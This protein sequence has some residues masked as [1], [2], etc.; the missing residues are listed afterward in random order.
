VLVKGLV[1]FRSENSNFRKESPRDANEIVMFVVITN[2]EGEGI[3]YAVVG[4]GLLKGHDCP[5]FRDPSRTERVKQKTDGEEGREK[6]EDERLVADDGQDQ[7]SENA[8][9]DEVEES[10]PFEGLRRAK[11]TD[12]LEHGEQREP[13]GLAEHGVAENAVL[14]GRRNVGV[15]ICFVE[16]SVVLSVE[17]TEGDTRGDDVG[18]VTEEEE[19]GVE[20]GVAEDQVVS[21]FVNEYPLRV[22]NESANTVCKS[23][24]SEP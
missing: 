1:V 17:V 22:T 4:V 23:K 20:E 10:R 8:I 19:K 7:V 12:S 13:G 16:K 21:Q 15:F 14:D 6:E 5:V 11:N 18:G 9:T 2:V 3:D 24:Y